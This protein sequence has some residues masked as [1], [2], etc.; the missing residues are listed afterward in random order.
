M[1]AVDV[2]NL[3]ATGG[4]TGFVFVGVFVL[5]AGVMVMRWV[6]SSA[7]RL[8]VVVAPIVLL[9]G[10]VFSPSVT[11]P[12]TASTTTDV[13]TT[14]VAPLSTNLVLEI[15]TSLI[16]AA[17]TESITTSEDSYIF[18]LGLFGSVNVHINWG[19][20]LTDDVSVEGPFPHTYTDSGQYTIIVSGSLT[21]FGQFL[22]GEQSPL[23]GAQYLTAVRSFGQLGIESLIF[24]FW[25]SNNLV[26]VPAILPSTVTNLYGLFHGATSFNQNIGGWD[27]SKV[28][29]MSVMFRYATSFN[30]S[31]GS[32]DVGQVGDMSNMLDGS[33]LSVDNY[34]ATLN[35]WANLPARQTSVQ[36]GAAGLHYSNNGA[37]SHDL[38]MNCRDSYNWTIIDE[39]NQDITPTSLSDG[40]QL[41]S[42]TCN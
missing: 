29:N 21:G 37:S 7:G 32:W 31:L 3:P 35:G 40:N 10:L 9:G 8:S 20:G 24:S 12:C 4:A 30:Q 5:I 28:T 41:V 39:G 19:D 11:D 14:T 15:D 25:G 36:L 17:Q 22:S 38:L 2:C 16:G 18:E 1:F 6:R 26:D 13:P 27:T 42:L 34:D 33:G 23:I